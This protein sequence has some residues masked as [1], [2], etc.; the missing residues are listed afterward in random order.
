MRTCKD[1]EY[2]ISSTLDVVNLY[3]RQEEKCILVTFS[4]L[5][6]QL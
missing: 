6:R 2:R 1:Y 5:Y 4:G 3:L